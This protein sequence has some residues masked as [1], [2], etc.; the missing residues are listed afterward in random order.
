MDNIIE[1]K[2]PRSKPA[3]SLANG[4]KVQR[5]EL[6]FNVSGVTLNLEH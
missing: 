5:M 1:F 6:K 3:L 2:A 4:F